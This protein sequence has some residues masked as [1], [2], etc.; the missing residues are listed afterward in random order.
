M[1]TETNPGEKRTVRVL[2]WIARILGM[3][4]GAFWLLIMVVTVVAELISN[5][6][7][8]SGEGEILAGLVI[9]AFA[10]V[11]IAWRRE[12]IGGAVTLLTGVA[13]GSFSYLTAG[14]NKIGI[15]LLTGAPFAIAGVLFLI[16]G[17][18]ARLARA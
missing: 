8:P 12:T 17:R 14:R 6:F 2:R 4:A 7:S 13:L 9:L 5:G 1:M 11:L 18:K 10:S 15:V 3:V 16:C